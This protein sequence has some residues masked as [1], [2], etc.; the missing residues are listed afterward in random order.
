MNSISQV[1]DN[2]IKANQLLFSLAFL[3][4]FKLLKMVDSQSTASKGKAFKIDIGLVGV[5]AVGKT[6]MIRKF[7]HNETI[8]PQA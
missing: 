7:I 8:N 2:K 4:S 5:A 6:S 1:N 3:L